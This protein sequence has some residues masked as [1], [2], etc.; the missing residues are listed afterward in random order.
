MRMLG[1]VSIP[2]AGILERQ[3]DP[4]APVMLVFMGHGVDFG[5]T[6]NAFGEALSGEGDGF[7]P[8]SVLLNG[9]WAHR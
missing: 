9:G 3:E 5:P 1:E 4:C 2:E 7:E 6:L 8:G